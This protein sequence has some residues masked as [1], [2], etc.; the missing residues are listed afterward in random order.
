MFER[1]CN[2]GLEVVVLKVRDGPTMQC[3]LLQR[4]Q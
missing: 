2:I 3:E 1:A 4:L